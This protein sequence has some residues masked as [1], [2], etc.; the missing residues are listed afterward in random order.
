VAAI[1]SG[2][3]D[4]GTA[5]DAKPTAAL[6]LTGREKV[7]LALYLTFILLGLVSTVLQSGS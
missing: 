1:F 4:G 3:G 2:A 7:I 5:P 6:V